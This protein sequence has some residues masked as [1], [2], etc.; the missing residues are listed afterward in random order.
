MPFLSTAYS[1]FII[2][3]HSLHLRCCVA[4]ISGLR[5]RTAAVAAAAVA[6]AQVLP[7]GPFLN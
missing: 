2:F 5:T 3:P 6:A 1:S 4:L 7:V